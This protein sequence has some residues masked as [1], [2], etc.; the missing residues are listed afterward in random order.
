LNIQ[1][2]DQQVDAGIAGNGNEFRN[3]H[4]V[5]TDRPTDRQSYFMVQGAY[6]NESFSVAYT[7]SEVYRPQRLAIRPCSEPV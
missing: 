2:I 4:T 3:V 5:L 6:L 7:E 1:I